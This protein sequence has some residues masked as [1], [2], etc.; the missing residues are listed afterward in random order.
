MPK[1]SFESR[2]HLDRLFSETDTEDG[3][4]DGPDTGDGTD[5]AAS[6]RELRGMI[7]ALS[8]QMARIAQ[9]A[10]PAETPRRKEERA[11]MN[12]NIRRSVRKYIE[13][14][15]YKA[16]KSVTRFVEEDLILAHKKSKGVE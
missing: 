8:A 7:N 12:L 13:D 16:H 11:R 9:S 2:D 10:P 14:E 6:I 3:R 5:T 4:G 15:A 1:K